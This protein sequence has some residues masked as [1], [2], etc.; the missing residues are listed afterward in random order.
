MN[1]MSHFACCLGEH[2]LASQSDAGSHRCYIRLLAYVVYLG[3][4]TN[5]I[6]A[7]NKL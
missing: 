3:K 7:M 5:A 2:F 6:D 1:G 4:V